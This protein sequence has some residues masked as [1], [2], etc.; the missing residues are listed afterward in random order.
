MNGLAV[1][2]PGIM[3]IIGVST[4]WQKN[5]RKK[6]IYKKS[7][8]A[9]FILSFSTDKHQI[10]QQLEVFDFIK[11]QILTNFFEMQLK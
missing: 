5:R 2:P 10:V 4:W 1:A 8:T 3:F 7:D 9:H 6:V 11:V